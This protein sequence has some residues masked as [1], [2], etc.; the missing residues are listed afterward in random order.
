MLRIGI[1]GA[2]RIAP[3]ALV[4][5]ARRTGRAVVTGVAARER[6]RAE[7]FARKQGIPRVLDSY[8]A[9][10]ADPDIDAVYNPLP[11]GLHGHW[12]IAALR[13]GKHVLCEKPFTANADEARSVAEVVNGNPGLVVMEAFHYQYHPFA[14]RL[15]EIVRSGEL[16]NITSID[17][18]F[19]AP[20]WKKGDIRY[21]LA[22]AGGAT[23]DMGCY[24]VSL[25][26]LL[27][28]GPRVTSAEAKLSSPGVDRAM[29]AHFS[30]PD[31]GRAHIGCSMFSSSVLRLHAEVTGDDG[32]VSVFNPFS[33]QHGHRMKVTT[34]LGTRKERFS[35]RPT[36]DYQLEAFVAAVEDG[37]PF[38]TTAAD[39][40]R[41]MELIDAI[42]TA[43]GLP[44]RQPTPVS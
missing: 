22:L 2:A 35:R 4:K 32:K 42:Y 9:L 11:N 15:V 23:M 28:P 1:L 14:K 3:T 31:G 19:S 37:A 13:A 16:G 10:I 36:Y 33:P 8:A 38:P 20:L 25:L 21:Q 5:P 27:A 41:T 18:A 43:A 34:A 40:I 12:T 29:D 26:R 39:A 30:L 17:V 6:P 24:P 44:V 7:E